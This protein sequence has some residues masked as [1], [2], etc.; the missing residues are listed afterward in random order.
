MRP[1]RD[2]QTFPHSV[3]THEQLEVVA[4][5]GEGKSGGGEDRNCEVGGQDLSFSEG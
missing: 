4:I 3:H 1:L 2:L 5:G